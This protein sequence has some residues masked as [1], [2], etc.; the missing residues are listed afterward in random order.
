MSGLDLSFLNNGKGPRGKKRRTTKRAKQA[1]AS[2]PYVVPDL[3][4][5]YAK[6]GGIVSPITGELI[7]SRKQLRAHER[8]H[9][10]KQCGDFRPGELVGRE[11]SK[12]EAQQEFVRKHGGHVEWV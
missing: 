9:N 7:T 11:R 12:H 8:Q 4:R 10:V 5:A 3:D 1:T 6:D 2:G